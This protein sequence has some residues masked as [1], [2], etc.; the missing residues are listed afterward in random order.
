MVEARLVHR[1]WKR[2]DQ[3]LLESSFMLR[4]ILC[5]NIMHILLPESSFLSVGVPQ[6]LT[7]R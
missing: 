7:H 5:I 2:Y 1:K 3:R 4:I 6:S